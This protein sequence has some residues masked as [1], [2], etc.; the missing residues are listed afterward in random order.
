MKTGLP[1]RLL[2]S[3]GACCIVSLTGLLAPR[4]AAAVVPD[5]VGNPVVGNPSWGGVT[6]TMMYTVTVEVDGIAANANHNGIVAYMSD[7][8]YATVGCD[9]DAVT[10]KNSKVQVF[11]TTYTRT[12]T[13]Y[14]FQPGEKRLVSRSTWKHNFQL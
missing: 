6:N 9:D 2:T 12:W 3:R 1:E 7:D 13:L 8:D 10:W 11:D 14:N 4:V 5:F